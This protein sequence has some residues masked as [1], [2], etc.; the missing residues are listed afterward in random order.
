V[1][2]QLPEI[3]DRHELEKALGFKPRKSTLA[4][5]LSDMSYGKELEIVEPSHGRHPARYR[6]TAGPV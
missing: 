4:R 5:I 2:P 6:K 3:F 1:L